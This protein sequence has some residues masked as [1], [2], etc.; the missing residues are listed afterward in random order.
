MHDEQLSCAWPTNRPVKV[1]VWAQRVEVKTS[2]MQGTIW[3]TVTKKTCYIATNLVQ[4]Y[5][6]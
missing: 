6:S 2:K 4:R 3:L 1:K 5:L